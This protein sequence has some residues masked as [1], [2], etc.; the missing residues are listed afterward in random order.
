MWQTFLLIVGMI[1]AIVLTIAVGLALLLLA[2]VS[3]MAG[4]NMLR[5]VFN[6]AAVAREHETARQQRGV[7]F[8]VRKRD[9]HGDMVT[10]LAVSADGLI[11]VSGGRD[12]TIQ[13]RG[14]EWNQEAQFPA[15]FFP[16]EIALGDHPDL[17]TLYALGVFR[18]DADLPGDVGIVLYNAPSLSSESLFR[19]PIPGVRWLF[20]VAWSED[21]TLR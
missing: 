6:P 8:F 7:S 2:F 17:G 11:V 4:L 10:A 1:V 21:S 19:L 5:R 18:E 13:V 20:Q 15:P 9:G 14:Q 16:G 3:V 12:R